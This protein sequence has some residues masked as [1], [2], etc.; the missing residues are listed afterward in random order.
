MYDVIEKIDN[1]IIQKGESNDRIYLMK[2]D[3]RDYP[4]MVLKLDEI[5]DSEGYSKIFAK[6]PATMKDFFLQSGYSI[7]AQVKNFYKGETDALFLGKY[8][9]D[10]R[11]H[12]PSD[13]RAQIEKN[14]ELAKSK[15]DK[16][17]NFELKAGFKM[18]AIVESDLKD[19]AELY[20]VVFK[21]YP[22]PIHD[23]KFLKS[24]MESH[25]KFFGVFEGEKLVAAASAE[26]DK[27][28]LNAEMTDFATNP[29]YLGNGFAVP[30]LD[31]MEESVSGEGYATSYTIARSMSPGMNI[32]FAKMGY[33]FKGVL[34]NNTNISGSIESMN[35]WAKPL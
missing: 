9:D 27:E 14:I 21:T 6:I 16:K 5:A 29:D 24:V 4:D 11:R 8:A 34:I 30:L 22:F 2:L 12:I 18:R 26:C 20:K 28:N 1:S 17:P 13:V 15:S 25:V 19:L 10:K 7:E 32:T 31:A 33:E 3:E 35:V 23:P